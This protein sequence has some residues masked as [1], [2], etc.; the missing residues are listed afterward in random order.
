MAKR[1]KTTRS[2][3]TVRYEKAHKIQRLLLLDRKPVLSKRNRQ[4]L[5]NISM[6]CALSSNRA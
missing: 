1:Q 2:N 3:K 5:L 4:T 6:T